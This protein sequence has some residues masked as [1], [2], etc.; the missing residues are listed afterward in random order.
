MRTAYT[1]DQIRAAE[2][3]LMATLP[4]GTLME[5]A[6][7]GLAVTCAG[8]L[9]TVYGSRVVLLVGGGDNG[10]DAL[11]AGARLADRGARVDAILAGPRVHAGGL[12]ALRR[13]GGRVTDLGRAAGSPEGGGQ[14]ASGTAPGGSAVPEAAGRLIRAAGLV[15][16]GLVGIG[17]AGALRE[18]YATLAALAGDA[19]GRVVAVDVPS[20]VDAS[21]GRVE[22]PAVRAD[23]TVTF[24]AWKIGLLVDPGA[25]YAGR[26]RLVDIGLGP[27]LPEPGAVA[28]ADADVA[29][30]LPVPDASA[31]K[32]RRGVVGIAAG[33]ERYTGAAVLAVGGAL[34]GGVGMVRYAGTAAPAARV[35]ARWPE[36]VITTLTPGQ[37]VEEVGRVQAW[38]LGPGLGTG[39]EAH[40]VARSVLDGDVPVLVDADGLTLLA[41]DRTLLRRTAPVLITPHAGE[42]SRLLGVPRERIEARRLEHA[43]RA[44]AE[45]GVTVLLKGSTTLVAEEGRPVVINLTGAPW[46]ATGGTGDVLAG[47]AGALLAGGLSGYDAAS[48][49]AHLHGIAGQEGPLAAG[50]V[51]E[52]LP[53]AVRAVMNRL[54]RDGRAA[55]LEK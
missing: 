24:G 46:L 26:A 19:P 5:R 18:P 15:V 30:L 39:Q 52:A 44:A 43:R 16:D 2:A 50:D 13:A 25:G 36:A 38:V 54:R 45:L 12:D 1:S 11:Y 31:D 6:A 53:G 32:Y 4:E 20:G 27:H 22:G 42:L 3:A 41:E 34:R 8:M 10:G 28:P 23:V 9:G 55:R 48:C 7:T 35:R 29:A 33:S 37:G 51:V 21:S 17:G 14:A 40:A 47:L 49:A